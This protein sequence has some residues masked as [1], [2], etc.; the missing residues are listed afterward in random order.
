VLKSAWML[1]VRTSIRPV[2]VGS[3]RS[4]SRGASRPDSPAPGIHPA[5]AQLCLPLLLSSAFLPTIQ[6]LPALPFVFVPPRTGPTAVQLTGVFVPLVCS[7]RRGPPPRCG[8][9][10]MASTPWRAQPQRYISSSRRRS[11]P[12]PASGPADA[13][14][15]RVCLP[16]E[17][18]L[19]APGVDPP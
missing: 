7:P 10:A 1:S 16:E 4:D 6:I 17:S 14:T 12:S 8:R 3:S 19:V 18:A 2:T 15:P 9:P 13:A 11:S 5:R